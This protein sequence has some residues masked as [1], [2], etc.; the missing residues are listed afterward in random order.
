LLFLK[1][2]SEQEVKD[3]TQISS[4]AEKEINEK[5]EVQIK[6]ILEKL[7]LKGKKAPNKEEKIKF[8][9]E[10]KKIEEIKSSEIKVQIKREF[11]YQI[12]IAEVEKAGISSTGTQIENELEP[13]VQ[14][15]KI[16]R[17]TKKLWGS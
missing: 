16:Y 2:F 4:K 9:M 1:K 6:S 13:L 7:S 5:Y 15:F 14:E 8:R 10:L 17:I 11:N 12:P 3:W